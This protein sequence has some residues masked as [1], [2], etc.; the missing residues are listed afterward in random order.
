MIVTDLQTI[1]VHDGP[2][3]CSYHE[4]TTKT[5]EIISR[6]F[7]LSE[8]DLAEVID[9]LTPDIQALEINA[10]VFRNSRER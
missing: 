3:A 6:Y 10:Q 5:L 8:E 7:D 2:V 9:R 4:P 1:Y